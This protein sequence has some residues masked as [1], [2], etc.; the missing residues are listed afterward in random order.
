MVQFQ[1]EDRDQHL[2]ID[3][4]CSTQEVRNTNTATCNNERSLS[5][6]QGL[7]TV[8]RRIHDNKQLLFKGNGHYR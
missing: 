5:F 8:E 1:G 3:R 2:D 6:M 7:K 4:Y